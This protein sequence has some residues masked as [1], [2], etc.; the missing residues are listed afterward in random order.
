MKKGKN[1]TIYFF[2][3][4]LKFVKMKVFIILALTEIL[5]KYLAVCKYSRRL[6]TWALSA[7]VL[8]NDLSL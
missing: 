1:R 7:K 5:R 3:F 8:S 6:L 2:L 4:E